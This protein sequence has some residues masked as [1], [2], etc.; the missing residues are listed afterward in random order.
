[1]PPTRKSLRLAGLPPFV[2][3]TSPKSVLRPNKI[4]GTVQAPV[5]KP[6]TDI[7]GKKTARII[8]R[9]GPS[10]PKPKKVVVIDLVNDEEEEAQDKEAATEEPPLVANQAEEREEE[11]DPEEY[12]P[13]Y[14]PHPPFPAFLS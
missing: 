11:E 1:M 12:A 13:P 4:L 14:S 2:P 5:K 8:A 6:P 3:S 7:K 10:R 9:G